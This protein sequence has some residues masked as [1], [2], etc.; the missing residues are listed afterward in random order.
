MQPWSEHIGS[1]YVMRTGDGM[2]DNYVGYPKKLNTVSINDFQYV[3]SKS[4]N[5]DYDYCTINF[6]F[7]FNKID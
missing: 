7:Y 4:C 3:C 6:W 2:Q 1:W 5:A